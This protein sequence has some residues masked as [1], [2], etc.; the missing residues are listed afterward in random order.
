MTPEQRHRLGLVRLTQGTAVC[1]ARRQG[2]CGGRLRADHPIPR[3][4][5]KIA[6]ARAEYEGR[7]RWKEVN[8]ALAAVSLADLIADPRNGQW[9]CERHDSRKPMLEL[10]RAFLDQ[11][12]LDFA[13]EYG[14]EWSLDIDYPRTRD[15][16]AL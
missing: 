13:A 9:L 10:T 12:V 11:R 4:R 8:A 6:K 14:L 5:L 7:L 1:A 15:L 3:S 2:R 16:S